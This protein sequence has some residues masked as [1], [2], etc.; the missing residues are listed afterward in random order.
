M[1]PF[2]IDDLDLGARRKPTEWV[3]V[4]PP[5]S[6]PVKQRRR[7]SRTSHKKRHGSTTAN[8]ST[9]MES[10]VSSPTDEQNRRLH[11]RNVRV[12]ERSKHRR[13]PKD[14]SLQVLEP[15]VEEGNIEYKLRI[16]DPNPIRLQ[17]LITQMKFRLSEGKGECF[18]YVGVEDNGYLRGLEVGDLEDSLGALRGMARV[19]QAEAQVV[20]YMQGAHGRQCALLHIWSNFSREVTYTDLRVAVAG[21]VDSGKSTL[22]A[23]LT[24]GCDGR[25]EL[26]NGRG[27]ARMNVFRHKHEIES[28]RTSSISQQIVGYDKEGKVLNYTGVAAPTPAEISAGADK[29][30]TFIDMGGHQKY[31]K[32]TLYGMTCMLPDYVLCCVCAQVGPTRMTREHLAVAV[33]LEIPVALVLTK[34]DLVDD[35]QLQQVLS[36]LSALV[37]TSMILPPESSPQ[38]KATGGLDIIDTEAEAAAAST[39]LSSLL[40]TAHQGKGGFLQSFLP[41]FL[42]SSVTGAGLAPLHAFL[43]SLQP[44]ASFKN[45]NYV[46]QR[47]AQAE[48]ARATAAGEPM[49]ISS[50]D[51][52]RL[53]APRETQSMPDPQKLPLLEGLLVEGASQVF[54]PDA[55]VQFQ[56]DQTFE[57]DQVGPVVSG[58]VVSGVIELGQQLLWGPNAYGGFNTVQVTCIQRSHLPVH[59]V[60]AGQMATVAFRPCTGLDSSTSTT[61]LP[62]FSG[63]LQEGL[64]A[65]LGRGRQS[66]LEEHPG[67]SHERSHQNDGALLAVDREP[68]CPGSLV[69]PPGSTN[70]P[71]GDVIGSIYRSAPPTSQS[72]IEPPPAHRGDLEHEGMFDF[73]EDPAEHSEL[74]DLDLRLLTLGGVQQEG[75]TVGNSSLPTPP[76]EEGRAATREGREEVGPLAQRLGITGSIEDCQG[77]QGISRHKTVSFSQAVSVM[78][79]PCLRPIFSSSSCPELLGSSP[80][81]SRKGA[82]LLDLSSEA[83][84]F[85]QFDTILILLGGYWPP[86]GL[87][88]GLWP[89]GDATTGDSSMG[90]GSDWGP[91]S[92]GGPEGA[93]ASS[94]QKGKSKGRQVD[95]TYAVHCGSVRQ[96]A[97]LV[98]MREVSAESD[99]EAG[100]TS[101][102]MTDEV[103]AR[104]A[105][106]ER[107]SSSPQL[108]TSM[109]AAA[110]LVQSREVTDSTCT[111]G[112]SSD[113]GTRT[114]AKGE[115][116]GT[117]VE[118]RFRFVQRPEWLHEGARL[119]VRDRCT[120]GVAATGVI[121]DRKSV[122]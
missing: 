13:E 105:S 91:S 59:R 17:Q 40:Q 87:L 14:L 90:S 114:P 9:T 52:H 113:E 96:M 55:P 62:L 73:D 93:S 65:E 57:V 25:P 8:D 47:D 29:V 76:G 115:R 48:A 78:P 117:V 22:V 30:L 74:E 46:P 70:C 60:Q 15:E 85:W 20:K 31:L 38:L 24:H 82:V 61:P 116:L 18:Y 12:D 112:G 83:V 100:H 109:Q 36:E 16:K 71:S 43:S 118:A 88:T 86:R 110:A 1:L 94:G 56:V 32:T 27:R 11:E 84:T 108:P 92:G 42:V 3:V 99:S 95:F 2:D 37:C 4:A 89:P 21:S 19:L 41:T 35:Q 63:T 49:L 50:P 45:P 51:K 67:L 98:R 5:C 53:Q 101:E 28:G 111:V 34:V 33:A 107:Q 79:P 7:K 23:V 54:E 103:G 72:G 104:D 6:K 75:G 68:P 119:I 64:R 106:F 102:G 26:D 81:N 97:R 66:Y 39:Q 121:T 44:L 10:Q 77:S 122:V 120:G 58:T 69:D 80:P